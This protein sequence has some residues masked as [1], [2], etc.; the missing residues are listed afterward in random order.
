[1]P[2]GQQT[3]KQGDVTKAVKAVAAAGVQVARVTID[4]SGKITVETGKPMES[5]SGNEWDEVLGAAPS[6]AR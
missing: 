3:F 5:D 6:E 1:M 2:R 4:R